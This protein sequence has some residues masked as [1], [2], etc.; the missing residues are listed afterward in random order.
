MNANKLW[1]RLQKEESGASTLTITVLAMGVLWIVPTVAVLMMMY[2]T[3]E[4]TQAGTDAASLAAAYEFSE[5]YKRTSPVWGVCALGRTS[6]VM[7][8][9]GQKSGNYA[10]GVSRG[11]SAATSYAS[12]NDVTLQAYTT[13]ASGRDASRIKT[14][15][16]IPIMTTNVTTGTRKD[17]P[18][19]NHQFNDLGVAQQTSTASVYLDRATVHSRLCS[20]SWLSGCQVQYG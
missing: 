14:V 9:L 20:C 8:Y 7:R 10:L 6:A 1:Q 5:A 16:G 12:N 15:A 18:N 2:W 3:A 4:K 13:T 11:Y 17:V 19:V